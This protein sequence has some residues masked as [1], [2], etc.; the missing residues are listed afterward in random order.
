MNYLQHI[1]QA[2]LAMGG[3][4]SAE[5]E[6]HFKLALEEARRIDPQGPREAEVLN[7]MALFYETQG[8]QIQAELAK[9]K[10]DEIF[11]KFQES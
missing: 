9:K 6:E 3:Q 1:S 5:A 7:Y 4:N 8:D 10:A 11:S 2:M